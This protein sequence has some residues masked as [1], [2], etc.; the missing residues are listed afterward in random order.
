M[1]YV[2][3][4]RG[5]EL[6]LRGVP[7]RVA[8]KDGRGATLARAAESQLGVVHAMLNDVIADQDKYPQDRQLDFEGF[9]AY[10][11]SHDAFTC[12][13]DASGECIGAFY[14]KPNF[15]GRCSHICNAGFLVPRQHRGNG[16]GRV[17][18]TAFLDLAKELG[19]RAV[20]FNLVFTSPAL[21]LYKSL[22]FKE[23]GTVPQAGLLP[24]GTYQDATQLH[25]DLT[26]HRMVE[27]AAGEGG[28]A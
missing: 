6:A 16:V 20:F 14:I 26:A 17:M 1:A 8:L 2:I 25:Y 10:Y 24:D 21:R 12:V 23:I 27:P 13:D 18:A 5:E 15:P 11:L 7:R 4:A 28:G 19:Y 3:E 9:R 22:G